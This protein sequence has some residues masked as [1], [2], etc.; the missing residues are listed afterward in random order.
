MRARID[1]PYA[2]FVYSIS[3]DLLIAQ[4]SS[5]NEDRSSCCP[6]SIVFNKQV[7]PNFDVANAFTNM[8]FQYKEEHPFEK[9]KAEG[10]KI[11]RKYPDRVPVS[12]IAT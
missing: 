6:P 7:H 1:Y 9:R 2:I 4:R 8:K 10:E 11:R 5:S 12:N 3:F